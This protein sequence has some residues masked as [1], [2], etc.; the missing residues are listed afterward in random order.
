MISLLHNGLSAYT[1]Q[2]EYG[3][4]SIRGNSRVSFDL[5]SS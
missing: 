3:L 4:I 5:N 2:M 1:K